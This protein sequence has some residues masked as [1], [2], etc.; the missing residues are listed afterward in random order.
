MRWSRVS[1]CVLSLSFVLGAAGCGSSGYSG[2]DGSD[3]LTMTFIGL[4]GEGLEQEDFVGTTSADV[5][6]CPTICAF[7]GLFEDVET[8][9]FTTT[10]ANAI[11]VNNGTANIRLDSYTVS[12]PDSGLPSR[13]V[14]MSAILPGGVCSNSTRQCGVDSD[15]AGLGICIHDETAIEI[16]LFDFTDKLLIKGDAECPE[17]VI[18]DGVPFITQGTVIPITLQTNITFSGSDES[19]ERFTVTAGLAADFFDANN[20]DSSGGGG[21]GE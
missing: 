7:T 20:C 5:D 18:I 3:A 17:P 4:T 14:E 12:I 16:L 21:E 6:V 11:F 19:G 9:T 13:T 8:E 1:F 10:R 15:C 2:S